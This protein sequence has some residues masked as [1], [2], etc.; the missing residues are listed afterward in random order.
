MGGLHGTLALFF[1]WQSALC[2]KPHALHG[3]TL[4]P[5]SLF[6]LKKH[7]D[8]NGWFYGNTL[9]TPTPPSQTLSS[10]LSLRGVPVCPRYLYLCLV[11]KMEPLRIPGATLMCNPIMA[12]FCRF[13]RALM[14]H[15]WQQGSRSGTTLVRRTHLFS[16]ATFCSDLL[17]DCFA[18]QTTN[19]RQI[20]CFLPV[21][22]GYYWGSLRHCSQVAVTLTAVICIWTGFV[23][24]FQWELCFLRKNKVTRSDQSFFFQT[25]VCL[26]CRH[27]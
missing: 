4:F 5:D 6:G 20:C 1:C 23:L 15:I 8:E 3:S 21:G 14:Q 22:G 2:S 11:K 10:L 24:F 12:D 17:W 9:S 18:A 26:V 19:A 7:T 27:K 16:K 13:G 25:A